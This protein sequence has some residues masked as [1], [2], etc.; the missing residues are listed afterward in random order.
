MHVL[1]DCPIPSQARS[2]KIA[3]TCISF[4]NDRD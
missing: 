1:L 4:F 2:G 3:D